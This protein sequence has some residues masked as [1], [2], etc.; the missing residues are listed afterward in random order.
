VCCALAA[1]NLLIMAEA[2]EQC[3][4]LFDTCTRVDSNQTRM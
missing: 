4:L 3:A 2:K 1:A